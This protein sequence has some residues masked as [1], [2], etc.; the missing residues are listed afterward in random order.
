MAVIEQVAGYIREDHAA[1]GAKPVQRGERDQAVTGPDIEQCV[2]RPQW[3]PVEHFVADAAERREHLL[4]VAR[5]AAVPDLK[6]PA[7]PLIPL[8]RHGSQSSSRPGDPTTVK[9]PGNCQDSA[10][11]QPEPAGSRLHSSREIIEFRP[12]N[13]RPSR[14]PSIAP[15]GFPCP[16]VELALALAHQLATAAAVGTTKVEHDQPLALRGPAH[17]P[18]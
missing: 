9:R 11:T 13:A 6:Q 18:A 4:P 7:M 5:I 10:V 14:R 17:H 8:F 2:V 12:A 1:V 3:R 16:P 15:A